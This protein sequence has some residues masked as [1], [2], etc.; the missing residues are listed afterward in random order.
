ME[1][2]VMSDDAIALLLAIFMPVTPWGW[3]WWYLG[4]KLF[5]FCG[6]AWVGTDDDSPPG[7]KG[8]LTLGGP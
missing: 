7:K 4:Y 6:K 3:V 1:N 8:P 5:F 2:D